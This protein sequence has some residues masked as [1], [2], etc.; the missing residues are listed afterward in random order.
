MLE[1]NQTHL[2]FLKKFRDTFGMLE[3]K[4][5]TFDIPKEI[6]THLGCKK[7]SDTFGMLE[8]IR[9]IKKEMLKIIRHI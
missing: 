9:H 5:D 7:K 4:L 8:I 3:K 1:E 6:H 2:R